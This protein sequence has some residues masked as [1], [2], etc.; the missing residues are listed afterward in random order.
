MTRSPKPTGFGS[1]EV[2]LTTYGRVPEPAKLK[3][4]DKSYTWHCTSQEKSRV[5]Y[6][7]ALELHAMGERVSPNPE[8]AIGKYDGH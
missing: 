7:R 5:T 8:R 2:Q 3:R 4:G 1:P 6:E